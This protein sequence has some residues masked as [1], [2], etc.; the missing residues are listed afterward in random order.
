[1]P[2][3]YYVSGGWNVICD[4][5]G[6]K[7]KASEAKQRWDGL[8]VCP[9]DFEMRQ[10]Q[11]FVKAR[12]DKIT[13]PF[14]R[15]RPTDDFIYT[16]GFFDTIGPTDTEDTLDYIVPLSGYFLEDYMIDYSAFS[17]VMNWQRQFTDAVDNLEEAISV[18]FNTG[19]ITD[20]LT[21]SETVNV[22]R[23]FVRTFNDSTTITESQANTLLK[24]L[25]DATTAVDS[26]SR[27]V[28]YSRTISDTVDAPTDT[29][30]FVTKPSLADTVTLNESFNI[31]QKQIEEMFDTINAIDSGGSI[32]NAD[33]IDATY[34]LGNDYVGSTYTF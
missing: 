9:A 6:K 23:R 15:P 33:Y 3:N 22:V 13:V 5:C 28:K 31:V 11:D 26:Y 12:A 29:L 7:I 2:R 10:P 4:S 8:I 24:A 34:F 25:S 21:L 14:T 17:I 16:Q 18:A 30:S 1:M 19:A 27:T 32:F 20:T